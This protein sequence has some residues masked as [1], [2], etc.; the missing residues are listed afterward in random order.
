[1]C[2]ASRLLAWGQHGDEAVIGNKQWRAGKQARDSYVCCLQEV[3]SG[4]L[5]KS[6]SS[7]YKQRVSSLKTQAL[8][9]G[10]G[11]T[12]PSSCFWPMTIL[13]EADVGQSRS[14]VMEVK[15]GWVPISEN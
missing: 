8:H 6:D 14:G 5:L 15:E 7:G 11:V 12:E 1:M 10:S 9:V 2:V 13:P 4:W 3:C